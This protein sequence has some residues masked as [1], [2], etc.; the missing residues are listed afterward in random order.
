V[1]SNCFAVGTV[2]YI[3]CTHT[4]AHV[5][6]M[7]K[8]THKH[9]THPAH[10][11]P[12]R[13]PKTSTLQLTSKRVHTKTRPWAWSN[14]H[15]VFLLSGLVSHVGMKQHPSHAPPFRFGLAC[16]PA[17]CLRQLLAPA[18]RLLVS[19]IARVRPLVP[20]ICICCLHPH[21]PPLISSAAPK[22]LE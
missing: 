13:K 22:I 5:C 1:W 2:A 4:S 16:L 11:H 20:A 14:I 10:E 17:G 21:S 15:L 18:C 9:P 19:S 3:A 6:I 12:T 7:C 8:T